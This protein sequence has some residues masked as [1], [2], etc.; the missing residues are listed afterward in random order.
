MNTLYIA[1]VTYGH[2]RWRTFLGERRLMLS[3]PT[4]GAAEDA[5]MAATDAWIGTDRTMTGQK[6]RKV[7]LQAICRTPDTVAPSPLPF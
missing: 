7:E 5:A 1:T 4:K 6:A 2:P 3:A